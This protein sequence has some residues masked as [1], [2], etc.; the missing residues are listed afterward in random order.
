MFKVKGY[1]L[2]VVGCALLFAGLLFAA[3]CT[4]EGFVVDDG[5]VELSF[6]SDTLTFD[7]VFATV[8]TATRRVTVY[9]RTSDHLRLSSITL[10]KGRASRF[11][12]NVDGDTSL[13][14]KDIEIESGDSV[15]IFVQAHINP[16]DAREPFLV[17]DAIVFSNGQRLSL[18]AWGR[19]AVYH[20]LLPTDSTWFTAIDCEGWDHTLPHVFV[21]PAAVLEGN[22]LT[23]TAGDELYFADG[24]LLV[25]DSAARLIAQGTAE[26]PDHSVGNVI[27]HAVVEN[28]VGGLR[29]YPGSE[30]RVTNTVVRNMSD[31]GIIGQGA[32]ISGRN[33]LVYDCYASLTVLTGGSYD[34]AQCTFANYW[35]YNV[36]KIETV[37]L[38]N[39]MTTQ[40]GVVGGDLHRAS[41]ED[42]I[43]WGSYGGGE[44]LLNAIPGYEMNYSFRNCIVRGGDRDEDPL[45][46]DPKEDDYTLQEGSPAAGIGYSFY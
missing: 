4:E 46:T 37:V 1:R 34:F 39:C 29:G 32:T 26:R 44:V 16:N 42:C 9:N 2:K 30:V 3:G 18:T 23:L 14:A 40:G 7:T 27:D 12:L 10:E 36:R 24:A 22:T 31:C 35:T 38:S 20:R 25:V 33:L 13:V 43:V 41:F 19:N 17:E 21:D 15:F 45:F 11:R 8:G 6:S 5:R 28:A